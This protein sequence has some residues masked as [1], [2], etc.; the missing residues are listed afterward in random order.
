VNLIACARG[1]RAS[2]LTTAPVQFLLN[3]AE[4]KL[5]GYAWANGSTKAAACAL[6]LVNLDSKALKVDGLMGADLL[7][8]I[9][10]AHAV[11]LE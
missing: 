1:F 5:E 11:A 10:P 7:A 9:A 4:G 3:G 8:L 6:H 2:N